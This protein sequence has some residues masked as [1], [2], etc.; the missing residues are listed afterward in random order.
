MIRLKTWVREYPEA[1]A[2]LG[3]GREEGEYVIYPDTPD[4]TPILDPKVKK[5]IDRQMAGCRG[6]GDSVPDG[7]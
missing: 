5:T 1:A 4:P 6:C 7:I 3:Q 2:R